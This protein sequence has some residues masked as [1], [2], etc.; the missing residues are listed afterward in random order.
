MKKKQLSN[1]QLQNAG[2]HTIELHPEP[3]ER[4]ERDGAQVKL[5]VLVGDGGL[6]QS[7]VFLK[8][9][10]QRMVNRTVILCQY[11][12]GNQSGGSGGRVTVVCMISPG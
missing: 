8:K 6:D 4:I 11:F 10:D 3:V 5:P 2:M 9:Q 7:A 12:A 1:C